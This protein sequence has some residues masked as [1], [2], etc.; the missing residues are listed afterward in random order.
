MTSNNIV[1]GCGSQLYH[2]RRGVGF[3]DMVCST[4]EETIRVLLMPDEDD[5]PSN[6]W[7]GCCC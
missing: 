6:D 5:T 1:C 4:C 3:I 2:V 7:S